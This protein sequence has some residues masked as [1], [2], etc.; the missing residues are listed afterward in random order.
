[1]PVEVVCMT[2]RVDFMASIVLLGLTI[3][4]SPQIECS[5]EAPIVLDMHGDAVYDV[6]FSPDGS[7]LASGSYDNTVRLWRVEDGKPIGTL[8]GHTDQVFRI[9]FSPD[10]RS[11]A[12]CGGDG[13][14]IVWDLENKTSREVLSG[15]RDPML[16]VDYSADGRLI[17]TAGSHIQVWQQGRELW[18]TPHTE[19]F[20]S[21]AWSSDQQQ[22]ACGSRN[23]IQVHSVDSPQPTRKIA[24]EGGMVYQLQY[25][26]DGT[27]LASATSDGVLALKRTAD[28]SVHRSVSADSS[29]LFAVSFAPDGKSI[30]TGG[31]ERVIRKWTVPDLAPVA[32]WR[33]PEE[34]ILTVALFSRP[35]VDGVGFVRR[36]DFCVAQL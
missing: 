16:D 12:S 3:Q 28:F 4:I 1:M 35:E 32:E 31:R 22:I 5:A 8:H 21:V 18:A 7:K 9:A 27:W 11:L 30:L 19:A 15:H 33:G 10:G 26:P 36:Q 2:K 25:S 14:T 29:A 34:T 13:T 6:A 20:F 17:A 24:M 23:L